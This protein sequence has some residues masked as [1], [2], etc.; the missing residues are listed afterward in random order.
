[1]FSLFESI[2]RYTLLMKKVFSRPEKMRIY[3]ERILY[4]VEALGLNSIG[5]TAIISVFIGAAI[6]LQMSIS[7]ESPFI[8]QYLIGYATRETMTL[9]FSSTVVAISI[10]NMVRNGKKNTVATIFGRI[11]YEAEFTPIISNAS[12]CSV[13]RI[14]PISEAMFEPTLPARI[15]ATTV[16]ENSSVIV[17]RVA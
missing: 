9:E 2:G 15:R 11:R 14:V 1:M 3:R 17:S 7:L 5:L 6:T 8:P 13:I 4:E 16:D 12:I 10:L